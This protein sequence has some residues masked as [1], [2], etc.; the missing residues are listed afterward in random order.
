MANMGNQMGFDA[1]GA[2]KQEREILGLMKHQFYGESA[3]KLLLGK[4]L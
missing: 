3:E 4:A 2:Y 1:A